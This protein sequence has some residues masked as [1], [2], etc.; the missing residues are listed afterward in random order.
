MIG[1]YLG[2]EW[3]L[4]HLVYGKPEAG[5]LAELLPAAEKLPMFVQGLVVPWLKAADLEQRLEITTGEARIKL[6]YDLA[7]L[8]SGRSQ[9]RIYQQ[10]VKEF[11]ASPESALAWAALVREKALDEP[12]GDYLA[13]IERLK[14]DPQARV[15]VWV[16][17]WG[18]MSSL[19]AKEQHRYLKAM[20]KANI[21]SSSLM[22][23]YAELRRLAVRERNDELAQQADA[24]QQQS[25]QLWIDEQERMMK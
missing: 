12:V 16:T 8:R 24:L 13:Y 5:S 17:G 9:R 1:I 20:A 11:P 23:A 3:S 6:L 2:S 21:A 19:P 14:A 25:Q 7:A 4:R 22:E 18:A 10:I 15:G